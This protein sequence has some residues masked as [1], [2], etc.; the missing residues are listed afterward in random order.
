MDTQRRSTPLR[1]KTVTSSTFREYQE[2]EMKSTRT[3]VTRIAVQ[4]RSQWY[5]YSMVCCVPRPTG[6]QTSLIKAWAS[7]WLMQ[8]LMFGWATCEEIPMV[9]VISNTKQIPTHF[10]TLGNILC[11]VMVK[12][13][14]Q[15]EIMV[16]V[17]LHWPNRGQY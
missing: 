16:E 13:D 15:N 6:S 2:E 14:L 5:S 8:A 12:E 3:L 4:V 11:V 10:G 1:Q 17:A 9:Y 7:L